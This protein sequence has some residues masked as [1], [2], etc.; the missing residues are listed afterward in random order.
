MTI[1]KEV[2]PRFEKTYK[3]YKHIFPNGKVYVGITS[4]PLNC[5]WRSG[6]GYKNNPY[7]TRAIEKYGWDNVHHFVLKGDFIKDEA[8]AKE[9][10]LIQKYCSNNPLF[11]YNITSGGDG[12]LGHSHQLSEESK[13]K[14]S[15]INKGRIRTPE[16]RAHISQKMKGRKRSPEAIAK[17]AAGHIGLKHTENTR[18]KM[19]ESAKRVQQGEGNGFYGHTHS[20]DTKLKMSQARKLYW[21]Q[22]KGVVS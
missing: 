20:E 3:V 1:D 7:M 2:N 4:Q 12:Q 11:G 18:K 17:S 13:K 15:L 22:K 5:R 8:N 10:E 6:K 19:S 9:K 14:I 16:M 21:Q